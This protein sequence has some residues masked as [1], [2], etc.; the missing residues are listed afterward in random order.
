MRARAGSLVALAALLLAGCGGDGSMGATT[1]DPTTGM[2]LTVQ[3]DNSDRDASV[4]ISGA[5]VTTSRK[6]GPFVVAATKLE[7]GDTL[8]LTFDAA[9][10]GMTMICGDARDRDGRMQATGCDSFPVRAGEIT[11]GTLQ[12]DGVFTH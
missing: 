12:L 8:G 7:T 3:Y 1:P 10:A 11:F 4:A 5:T 2:T 9:D 6:F